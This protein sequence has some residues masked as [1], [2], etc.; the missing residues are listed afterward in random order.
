MKAARWLLLV[1]LVWA[2][3]VPAAL[4]AEAPK[5]DRPKKP[6]PPG[7]G[8][9]MLDFTL[10]TPRGKKVSTAKVRKGK[11]FVLKFGATWCGWCNKQIPEL[12]KVKAA[13]PKDVFVLDVDIKE[14]AK[15]VRRHNKRLG[16][17]YV[18]V[19]DDMGL[20]ATRYGARGIPLV[21][22]A[23]KQ[24][25]IAFRGAYTRFGRMK[26]VIDGLLAKEKAKKGDEAETPTK[27]A[28]APVGPPPEDPE[29]GPPPGGPAP[30]ED[31][32]KGPPPGF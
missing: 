24:G 5:P 1:L 20:V 18:T 28:P 23:D 4:A 25:K 30:P 10:R 7:V 12:N 21:L 19:L 9:A 16:A 13:Y 32:D 22:I 26:V 2:V 6:K 15:V 17:K 3:A 8:D 29:K 11:L 31:L 27:V 14:P